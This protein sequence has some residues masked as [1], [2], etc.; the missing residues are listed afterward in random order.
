MERAVK[1]V[2]AVEMVTIRRVPIRPTF[3][4]THPNLRYMITPKMVSID[5]VNTPPNV[6]KPV[7]DDFR[8]SSLSGN[9]FFI[10]LF[11]P[12]LPEI[13]QSKSY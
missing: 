9:S 8:T 13:A 12:G 5:G 1:N 7:S 10:L 2:I 4:T 6:L 11:I 3:P